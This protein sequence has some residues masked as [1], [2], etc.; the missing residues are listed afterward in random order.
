[1][2]NWR[3]FR[4]TDMGC[5]LVAIQ[6]PVYRGEIQARLL[7]MA[8]QV[9]DARARRLLAKRANLFAPDTTPCRYI[10]GKMRAM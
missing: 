9:Y 7:G 3:Q 2:F 8:V 1:M 10:F 6:Q 5:L 4:G